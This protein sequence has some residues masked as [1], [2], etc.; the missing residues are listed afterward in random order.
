MDLE[1]DSR[2]FEAQAE[3]EMASQ[4]NLTHFFNEVEIIK[5]DMEKVKK[6]L[7]ELQKAN[8]ESMSI[9]KAHA[10]KALRDRMDRDVDEVLKKAKAIKGRLEDLDQANLASR[11]IYGC[12]Q[13]SSTDRTRMSIT[14]SLRKTLRD[15]MGEFRALR[16]K[17][18][19]EYK[20]TIERRYYTVTGNLAD[21]DVIDHMIDTGESETF[22]LKAI[23]E[24]GK[25]H[26]IDTIKEIQERHETVKEIEK[27]LMELHQIFLDMAVLVEA[28]GEQLNNIEAAV[29]GASSFV[30]RG[31][32]ELHT[33]KKLQRNTRKCKCIALLIL[34]VIILV[35]LVPIL[36]KILPSLSNRNNSSN[37][38]PS[39]AT[40]P[41]TSR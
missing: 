18:M 6:L 21:E 30:K 5:E 15:L 40:S 20:E 33:A 11:R 36:V 32:E 17:M 38:T 25:G 28:Q 24:Q 35:V 2:D 39:T 14:N 4:N 10:M 26:I 27:N 8:S 34:L 3:T 37:S 22:L 23:Q 9:T 16:E 29:H 41:P 19:S 13:G 1:R 12:E 7:S 31:T